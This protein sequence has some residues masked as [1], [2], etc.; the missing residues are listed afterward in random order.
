[1]I[2]SS[3]GTV[4]DQISTFSM[5]LVRDDLYVLSAS[6]MDGK[7]PVN[8]IIINLLESHLQDLTSVP[9]L[10]L[11][12]EFVIAFDLSMICNTNKTVAIVCPEPLSYF[13]AARVACLVGAYDLLVRN[14]PME[15]VLLSFHEMQHAEPGAPFQTLLA[16][17]LN[18]LRALGHAA[19]N[20]LIE[21]EAAASNGSN[22]GLLCDSI[23]EHI[24]YYGNVN[25]NVHIVIPGKLVVLPDPD[26]LPD[27]QRWLDTPS[28]TGPTRAFSARYYADLLVDLDIR[29]VANLGFGAASGN[30]GAAC[31]A[32]FEAA[33][34]AYED[35]LL[36]AGDVA[37]LM[38]GHD[39]LLTLSHAIADA[40][41]A[42]ALQCSDTAAAR[43]VAR[44]VVT[45]VLMEEEGF[46][47][48]EAEA[49]LRLTCPRLFSFGRC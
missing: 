6:E 21:Y 16:D 32:A 7:Q 38:R 18:L 15:A 12:H 20:Q 5:L 43:T 14:T 8:P 34:V 46:G 29:L 13:K 31:A 37:E 33:G 48:A 41:G 17:I 47:A 36:P 45:A 42:I 44:T 39:R 1:V 40:G 19:K 30:A 3:T 35:D 10:S 9:S 25:G 28:A 23:D 49:W 27:G 11:I 4:K 24:H 22:G 26:D 2:A